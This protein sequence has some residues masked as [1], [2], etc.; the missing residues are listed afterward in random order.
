MK[1]EIASIQHRYRFN[2]RRLRMAAAL[3]AVFI[4][5]VIWPAFE[6]ARLLLANDANAFS[7]ERGLTA[8]AVATIFFFYSYWQMKRLTGDSGRTGTGSRQ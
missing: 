4:V 8:A 6:L 2:R 1:A 5:A 3:M 7:V